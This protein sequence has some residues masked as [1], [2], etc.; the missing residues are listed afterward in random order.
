ML[1]NIY[2][3][4][5]IVKCQTQHLSPKRL[6]FGVQHHSSILLTQFIIKGI[7]NSLVTICNTEVHKAYRTI[8]STVSVNVTFTGCYKGVLLLNGRFGTPSFKINFPPKELQRQYVFMLY[9]KTD[10]CVKEALT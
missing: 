5:N 6:P 2:E 1:L 10:V 3:Y 9:A 4:T 7:T 8:Y